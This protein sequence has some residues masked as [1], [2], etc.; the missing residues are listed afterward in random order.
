[1]AN[2][3]ITVFPYCLCMTCALHIRT[4]TQKYAVT[5]V[6]DSCRE[7]VPLHDWLKPLEIPG[8]DTNSFFPAVIPLPSLQPFSGLST[9]LTAVNSGSYFSSSRSTSSSPSAVAS[10]LPHGTSWHVH[11]LLLCFVPFVTLDSCMKP[12]SP[13]FPAGISSRSVTSFI[14]CHLI[15]SQLKKK[16]KKVMFCRILQKTTKL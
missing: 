16:K 15:R 4:H 14:S 2:H 3:W 8:G 7:L 10:R 11:N 9:G 13:Y 12:L 5:Y 1:M 6:T